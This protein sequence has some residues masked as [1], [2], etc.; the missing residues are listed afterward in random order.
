MFVDGFHLQAPAILLKHPVA[1]G[2]GN[3]H[4]FHPVLQEILLH[5]TEHGLEIFVAAQIMGGF[6]AAV[7]HY[8]EGGNGL[9]QMV[10]KALDLVRSGAGQGTAGKQHGVT[11][12]R[13]AVVGI[14]PG[15]PPFFII[16]DY[17]IVGEILGPAAHG[18]TAHFQEHGGGI[19]LDRADRG[20]ELAEAALKGHQL[21]LGRGGIIGIGNMFGRAVLPQKPAFLAAQFALNAFFR[22]NA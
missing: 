20:A 8:A 22:L 12:C 4:V 21:A 2:A 9:A 10:K 17:A 7:E 13:Q 1:V 18:L 5:L 14:T 15:G 6:G 3:Q 11:V 19:D 16:Q